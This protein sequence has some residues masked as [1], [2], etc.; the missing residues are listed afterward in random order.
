L[1]VTL[2]QF[3]GSH[4]WLCSLRLI[5]K[6]SSDAAQEE[7]ESILAATYG[8]ILRQFLIAVSD[9]PEPTSGHDLR[10]SPVSRGAAA[11]RFAEQLDVM[12]YNALSL[13]LSELTSAERARY[14]ILTQSS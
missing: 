5:F 9:L 14:A 8:A 12:T 1:E 7:A 10:L 13:A 2:W 3:N 11:G 4:S 6:W